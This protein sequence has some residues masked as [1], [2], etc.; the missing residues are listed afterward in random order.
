[1]ASVLDVVNALVVSMTTSSTLAILLLL[2]VVAGAFAT[3]GSSTSTGWLRISG[4][5]VA[6]SNSSFLV[7]SSSASTG[8]TIGT[9]GTIVDSSAIRQREQPVL[10]RQRK[11]S[12]HQ[13]SALWSFQY[14][15]ACGSKL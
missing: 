9:F 6:F 8:S 12:P 13:I 1:M 15:W 5:F 4:R 2:G 3:F 7:V 10:P 14:I 11:M